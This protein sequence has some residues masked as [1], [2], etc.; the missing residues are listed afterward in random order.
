M[1][2]R[3]LM[4]ALAGL[5]LFSTSPALAAADLVPIITGVPD[6]VVA[7]RNQGDTASGPSHA[8]LTCTAYGPPSCPEAPG[9]AAYENPAFPNSAT[10]D[11]PALEPGETYEHNLAFFPDLDFGPGTYEFSLYVDHGDAVEEDSEFNN[12]DEIDKV[13]LPPVGVGPRP[14]IDKFAAKPARPGVAKLRPVG[15]L[16]AGLPNL[17][18]TTL[19]M[20]L[21][22][23]FTAWGKTGVI[24]QPHLAE[25]TE[26]GRGGK[27][28]LF[29]QLA[30]RTFN[31]SPFAAGAFKNFVYRGKKKV[32]THE[33][34]LGGHEGNDWQTFP[35]ALAEGINV[36]K[37]KIDA[38]NAVSESDEDNE[39]W[40]KANVQIDCDG[41]G[42]IGGKRG[43]KA[44]RAA[45]KAK[46]AP[47][48]MELAPAA[49][50]KTKGLKLKRR[51]T[52]N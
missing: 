50:I 35:L 30:Y 37:V 10:V 19:G 29:P 47:V 52:R 24:D 13:V 25:E 46:I 33:L 43:F 16:A 48:Q 34:S 1:R 7:V 3:H 39:F 14:K 51:A 21:P 20:N 8:T 44:K 18:A 27:L 9:M 5:S 42:Q 22:S 45:A 26:Y 4:L 40:V 32:H 17:M 15:G 28:C 38:Q 36:I 6:G 12:S 2:K 41:D 49:K 31:A 11:I 23:G